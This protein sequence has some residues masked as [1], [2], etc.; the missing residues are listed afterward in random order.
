MSGVGKLED[1]D[2]S[3]LMVPDGI[4]AEIERCRRVYTV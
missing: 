2:G 4:D 3:T 1:G